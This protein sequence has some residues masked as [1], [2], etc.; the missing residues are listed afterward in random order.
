MLTSV[1]ELVRRC[2]DGDESLQAALLDEIEPLVFGYVRSFGTPFERAVRLT[3]AAVLGFLL[4]LR[5]GR[6]RLADPNALRRACHELAAHKMGDPDPWFVAHE[7]DPETGALTPHACALAA[8]IEAAVAEDDVRVAARRLR[9]RPDP[10]GDGL[11]AALSGTI[12][13]ERD[14]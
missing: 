7:G 9:G 5:A 12:V 1:A 13:P 4:D 2:A 10:A 3:H 14:A 11:R 8:Q 6:I